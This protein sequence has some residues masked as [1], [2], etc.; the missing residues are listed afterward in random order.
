MAISCC[1][2][3]L[4]ATSLNNSFVSLPMP[5]L[6]LRIFLFTAQKNSIPIISL[7]PEL[8]PSKSSTQISPF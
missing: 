4:I 8:K 6:I 1:P 2:Y 7:P 5:L 3:N